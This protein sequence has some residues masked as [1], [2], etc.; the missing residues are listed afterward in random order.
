MIKLIH[1]N[2]SSPAASP[3]DWYL[4]RSIA[5]P[6]PSSGERP[7]TVGLISVTNGG[8]AAWR[9]GHYK[10]KKRSWRIGLYSQEEFKSGI[11][12]SCRSGKSKFNCALDNFL[13]R[14]QNEKDVYKLAENNLK[15]STCPFKCCIRR[16]LLNVF[17]E[18]KNSYNFINLTIW[19][20]LI[21]QG[22]CFGVV[23]ITITAQCRPILSAICGALLEYIHLFQSLVQHWARGQLELFVYSGQ[24]CY[25]LTGI[26]SITFNPH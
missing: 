20:R 6:A 9:H 2:K 8:W 12:H 21:T 4:L 24:A 26:P 18:V 14:E 16:F 22:I 1:F 5:C 10:W 25:T 15:C 3:L 23:G 7:E 17:T 13:Y 11:L 19:I